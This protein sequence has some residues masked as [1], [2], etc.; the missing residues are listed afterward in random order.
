MRFTYWQ[1]HI[2][3][4]SA[5]SQR[6]CKRVAIDV[7]ATIVRIFHNSITKSKISW[8]KFVAILTL[9]I[10]ISHTPNKNNHLP[11]QEQ[12]KLFIFT[13][14]DHFST[15]Y[16]IYINRYITCG[17]INVL[18]SLNGAVIANQIAEYLKRIKFCC[19]IRAPYFIDST[20]SYENWMFG[21]VQ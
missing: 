9:S 21:R 7:C 5:F 6:L 17:L 14:D 4:V 20:N 11:K 2:T 10:A 12:K 18:L 3:Q 13:S 1:R 16:Y 15:Q 19:C 8:L